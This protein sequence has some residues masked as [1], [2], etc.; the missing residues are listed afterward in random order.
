MTRRPL[1]LGGHWGIMIKARHIRVIRHLSL[2]QVSR[3]TTNCPSHL[4]RFERGTAKLGQ[5]KLV[6][7]SELYQVPINALLEPVVE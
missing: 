5:Y 2:D 1:K 6:E 7:L 3:E 4:A